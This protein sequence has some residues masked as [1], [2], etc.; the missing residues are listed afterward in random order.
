LAGILT[1]WVA[2]SGH[3]AQSFTLQID[4]GGQVI[5]CIVI[6]DRRHQDVIAAD[7]EPGR[8]GA[9]QQWLC[10]DNLCFGLT[11]IHRQATDIHMPG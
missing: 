8:D 10:G 2:L 1:C 7:Q 4:A 5:G 9:D 11:C 3:R 6:E